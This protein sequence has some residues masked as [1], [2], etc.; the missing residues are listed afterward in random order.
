MVEL[1]DDKGN[2]VKQTDNVRVATLTSNSPYRRKKEKDVQ[3]AVSEFEY[4]KVKYRVNTKLNNGKKVELNNLN[5]KMKGFLA[6]FIDQNITEDRTIDLLFTSANDSPHSH[7]K[8]SKHFKDEAVDL[9]IAN[10]NDPLNDELFKNLYVGSGR[11]IREKYGIQIIDP[12]HG[13]APHIHLEFDP[14]KNLT[15]TIKDFNTSTTN[16]N[17]TVNNNQS[18]ENVDPSFNPINL[19]NL[20]ENFIESFQA[21]VSEDKAKKQK[22]EDNLTEVQK[23][24]LEKQ[25]RRNQA[26]KLI[27]SNDFTKTQEQEID[28]R[29][30]QQTLRNI[31]QS[32]NTSPRNNRLGGLQGI[33]NIP[34]ELL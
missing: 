5:P 3:F 4:N 17:T 18:I 11:K 26:L 32:F 16:T 7:G 6:E 1:K 13:S 24:L 31:E 25:A 19:G 15:P 27:N 22:N 9:R 20:E 14:N 2:L 21:V 8:G 10:S 28:S 12:R 29:A 33:S 23:R 30:L 34:S